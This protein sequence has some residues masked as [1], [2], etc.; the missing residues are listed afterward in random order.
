MSRS[1][2]IGARN[3]YPSYPSGFEEMEFRRTK[4][5]CYN[6]EGFSSHPSL[7]VLSPFTLKDTPIFTCIR[8][9]IEEILATFGD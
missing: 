5:R 8:R 1:P 4:P 9:S 2:Y 7:V 6:E 3:E